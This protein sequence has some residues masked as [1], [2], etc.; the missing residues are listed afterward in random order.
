LSEGRYAFTNIALLIATITNFSFY[1]ISAMEDSVSQAVLRGRPWGRIG[2]LINNSLINEII[3]VTCKERFVVVAINNVIFV[4]VYL[5]SD[6]NQDDFEVLCRTLLDV[7]L[8]L[9]LCYQSMKCKDFNVIVGGD[10]NVTLNG[11]SRAARRIE[12]FM[13]DWVLI[14]CNR[15]ITGNLNYTFCQENRQAFSLIDY[16]MIRKTY[17]YTCRLKENIIIDDPRNLSDHLPIKIK[18]L[19]DFCQKD[20]IDN[21]NQ[22]T[23]GFK[24]DMIDWAKGDKMK[25]YELTRRAIEPFVNRLNELKR[26]AA[27]LKQLDD[28]VF[29][30]IALNSFNEGSVVYSNQ[31]VMEAGMGIIHKIEDAYNSFD[32]FIIEACNASIPMKKTQTGKFWWDNQ[33]SIL[34][35]SS[36]ISLRNWINERRP[37]DSTIYIEKKL[38]KSKY[39]NY[40]KCLQFH[41]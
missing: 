16:F 15:I 23:D 7:E 35:E 3:Y 37:L 32:T 11:N 40:I 13:Y 14:P 24:P 2:I 22:N 36:M 8:N 41:K 31:S 1:G 30:S 5:P 19:V 38:A 39:K 9:D 20:N 27:E 18:I 33:L 4:N 12:E 6:K 26:T 21:Q 10:L 17:S 34:K 29:K 25:Y 28:S